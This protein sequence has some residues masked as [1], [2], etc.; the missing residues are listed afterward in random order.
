MKTNL[1]KAISAVSALALAG[2]VVPASFA[3]KLTLKDVA[4]TASYATAVNTLVALKVING[5]EDGTF[6]PDNL[7]T[8]AE[9]TKV[10][11]AALNQ[12]DSAESMK[13]STKFTD[14][15]AKH[16]WA[17]GFINA[18]VQAGYINGMG[19][20]TFAPDAN[21]T[22]AQM[23]KMLMS[24]MGYD[25]YAEFMGGYPNGYIALANSE[26]VA[27]G[28]KGNA[29][30][31][32]TRAQVAQ[33]VYN[34]LLA[35]IVDNVG[36]TYTDS[37]AVRPKVEKMDG[38]D[39]KYKSLLTEKFDAYYVEG[40]VRETSKSS[41]S[42]L[43]SDEVTF[44]IVKSENYADD[45]FVVE[46]DK[47]GK[48]IENK[49]TPVK[50]G[51]TDAA[52]YEGT[53]A[54]AI[55][56]VD[57][58]DDMSFISFQPSGKNK[59]Y[60]FD[61]SL[62]DEDYYDDKAFYNGTDDKG[63][64]FLYVFANDSASKSTKYSLQ[65]DD[66]KK[67]KVDIYV[68]GSKVTDE[69]K[70]TT[71]QYREYIQK[72]VIDATVGEVELVDTYK[73][74]GY[75]DAIYVNSYVTA[76][77]D[78][79][80]KTKI[81]FKDSKPSGISSLDLD[82]D[83]KDGLVYNIYYNGEKIALN[84]VKKD[85]VLSIS[86]NVTDAADPVK[87]NFTD[88]DHYDIYVSRNVQTGKYQGNSNDNKTVNIGG[89][90]Y[91]FIDDYATE[92]SQL[93]KMG[94]EYT[95]YLDYFNR[96]FKTEQ[97]ASTAKYAIIDKIA[98]NDSDDGYRL[99]MFTADG[100]KKILYLDRTDADITLPGETKSVK[101][102]TLIYDD[103]AK[104][105]KDTTDADLKNQQYKQNV[106]DRVVKYE[107]KTSTGRVKT[108]E[109]LKAT[110]NAA[111][112]SSD[113]KASTGAI[114]SV[115]LADATKVIDSINYEHNKYSDYADLSIA[116][117]DS[118][119]DGTGYEAYGFDK[120]NGNTYFQLVVVVAGKSSYNE[121]TRFAVVSD[122]VGT[123][124]D[125][126]GE[127]VGKIPAFWYNTAEGADNTKE[128]MLYTTDDLKDDITEGSKALTKGDVIVFKFDSN[129]KIED[130]EIIF[131]FDS[132][133]ETQ[134]ELAAAGIVA[135]DG[136]KLPTLGGAINHGFSTDKS[137]NWSGTWSKE[138]VSGKD[139]PVQ[140]VFGPIVA[141][142]GDKGFTIGK[143]ASGT[144]S[145][146]TDKKDVYDTKTGL[147]TNLNKGK[148]DD[149]GVY[150][151]DLAVDTAVY[152]YNYADAKKS[153]W[154]IGSSASIVKTTISDSNRDA[155]DSDVIPWD[156]TIDNEKVNMQ[157][158]NFAFAKVVDGVATDVVVFLAE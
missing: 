122:S 59:T 81:R 115:K 39:N 40:Y 52:D 60:K 5:Y 75:Y 65:T 28:V 99:T 14:V 6:L 63:E 22:Y 54:T 16:E 21:V 23:V 85:D 18:G 129:N 13:G 107:V 72:Y 44:G 82:E 124:Y 12:L 104:A 149:G 117:K 135:N 80:D 51:D 111:T 84:E 89:T 30:D 38:N 112:G 151:I 32:V 97:N 145:V 78:T 31:K 136:D 131:K 144:Y 37:G 106:Q 9:A 7:I 57:E 118:L 103:I 26:G 148:D 25:S 155:K 93:G 36:I 90:N 153:R 46:K 50:V 102:K 105:I 55:I 141:K 125:E 110:R 69:E 142:N 61:V 33:L 91:K 147:I 116:S 41:S 27:D 88:A 77:V 94:D 121:T 35:P 43:K 150:D 140:L 143:I 45:S 133:F 113:Y 108:L 2:S 132:K 101:T 98:N 152:E 123:E 154:S 79:V 3:A 120:I 119:V 95:I 70:T 20:G 86:Y 1:K 109:F 139:D 8:R 92:K 42:N 146:K 10:M 68:N 47:D 58:Y 48:V 19:D 29:D 126:S 34:A 53:Y 158:I 67:V 74:D 66:N 76:Q 49:K 114:G 137:T 138:D 83:K 56:R 11:V 127:E 156:L 62:V 130:Y 100:E 87:Q 24:A 96:I 128:V 4:D 73:T 17:T 134:S 15:E 71:A 157:N 64:T